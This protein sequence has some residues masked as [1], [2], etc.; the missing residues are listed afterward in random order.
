MK[1]TAQ[2]AVVVLAALACVCPARA[3]FEE[4]KAVEVSLSGYERVR[5]TFIED[6]DIS[7]KTNTTYFQQRLR[8]EPSIRVSESV[9]L[10]GQV[11][12][13]DDVV[14][15]NNSSAVPVFA[16]SP[17]SQGPDG[18]FTDETYGSRSINPKR[19]YADV[20]LPFGKL[21]FGRMP[22]HWGLGLLDNDG[23]GF[24][25]EWG[26]AHYGTTRDRILFATKPMGQ[27]GPMVFALGFDKQVS[28]NIDN[29]L[30]DVQQFFIIPMY[31]PAE[32]KVFAGAYA[33]YR[34][35][36]TTKTDLY[37]VSGYGDVEFDPLKLQLEAVWICLLYT[38]DAA[39]E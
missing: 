3:E 22:S 13:F 14:F 23:N 31:N 28:G 16:G 5:H 38:S 11:D 39:D 21:Q 15:G 35:Q 25:N 20:V 29:D 30:D 37:V 10:I 32:K 27:D 1:R 8:L 4:G 34:S 36:D 17:T 24:K 19:F 18:S 2:T 6:V 12:I 7:K 9:K 26:D 33:A